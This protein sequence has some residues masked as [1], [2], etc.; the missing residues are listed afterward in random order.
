MGEDE[1]ME[2]QPEIIAE[3]NVEDENMEN[4][5]QQTE[6]EQKTEITPEAVQDNKPD[7][8]TDEVILENKNEVEQTLDTP[9]EE[10]PIQ[11][12][13]NETSSKEEESPGWNSKQE[14]LLKLAAAEHEKDMNQ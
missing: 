7:Q 13:T 3:H 1:N 6:I 2:D 5:I 14:E 8:E 11:A 9:N 12:E 10:K 4:S